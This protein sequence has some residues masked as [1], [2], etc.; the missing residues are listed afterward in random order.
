MIIFWALLI[1]QSPWILEVVYDWLFWE[2][3]KS[4]KPHSTW[5]ARPAFLLVAGFF[6]MWYIDKAWWQV[7]PLELAGHALFFPL[8]INRILGKPW[9]YESPI[10]NK[11]S[12]DY[13]VAKIHDWPF[14]FARFWLLSVG[15][16]LFFYFELYYQ[17]KNLF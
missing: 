15:V 12:Y 2:S 14:M 17:T 7:F 13:W 6:V 10:N 9:H 4:D 8:V 3:G 11:W 5:I 1:T 16:C